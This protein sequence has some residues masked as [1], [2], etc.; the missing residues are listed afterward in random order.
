[1]KNESSV[2]ISL[3]PDQKS[4]AFKVAKDLYSAGCE[5]KICFT[6]EGKDMGDMSLKENTEMIK[7]AE[8]FTPY[9]SLSYRINSI[10][11]GSII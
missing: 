7:R 5:V 11:S 6:P 2:T 3:D 9:S 4:K 10:R 8:I 1:M